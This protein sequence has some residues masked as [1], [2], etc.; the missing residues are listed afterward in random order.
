M[1]FN[2]FPGFVKHRD[3]EPLAL[4]LSVKS[5]AP[6]ELGRVL[7]TGVRA[8]CSQGSEGN[9]HLPTEKPFKTLASCPGRSED[10]TGLRCCCSWRKKRE[11]R[12]H[13]SPPTARA[14]PGKARG[15]LR[16]PAGG[17]PPDH[18]QMVQAPCT[19]YC[20]RGCDLRFTNEATINIHSGP[21]KH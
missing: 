10:S 20:Q 19:G 21:K 11:V 8:N 16:G 9:L 18:G 12:R 15:S 2:C 13:H 14:A 17:S 7:P 3:I 1:H 4:I 6:E 5:G